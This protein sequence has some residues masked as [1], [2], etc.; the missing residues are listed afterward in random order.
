MLK[1]FAE[2]AAVMLSRGSLWEL[3]FAAEKCGISVSL[4]QSVFF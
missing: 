4:C 3:F 1:L 2:V